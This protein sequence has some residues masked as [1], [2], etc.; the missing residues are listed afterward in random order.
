VSVRSEEINDH[1]KRV[2]GAEF[3]AKD[4]RT[5]NATVLA[6]IA[7]ASTG[8]DA[9]TKTARKRAI[10]EA[11]R[12]VAEVLG[13][14]P[15]VARRAYIDPR[16]FDRYVAGQTVTLPRGA[17]DGSDDRTWARVER[18]VLELLAD[19]ANAPASLPGTRFMSQRW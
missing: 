1:V 18:A 11:V 15:A 7:L 8:S 14:T 4:F 12:G 13:N 16:L 2:A 5:W 9:S 19:A 6:A 10:E 3:S 17:A